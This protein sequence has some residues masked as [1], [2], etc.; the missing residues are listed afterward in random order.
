MW[1]A[2]GR[3]T[4]V[5]KNGGSLACEGVCSAVAVVGVA[6]V[7]SEFFKRFKMIPTARYRTPVGERITMELDVLEIRPS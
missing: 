5:L 2:D 3:R 4:E 7:S 1:E 6:L